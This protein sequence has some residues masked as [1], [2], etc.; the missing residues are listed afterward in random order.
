MAPKIW[1]GENLT[2]FEATKLWSV[3]FAWKETIGYTFG[4]SLVTSQQS[5]SRKAEK[6]WQLPC[7]G[8]KAVGTPTNITV[9]SLEGTTWNRQFWA[10][11]FASYS[12]S[13]QRFLS[14]W[15][16]CHGQAR[17]LNSIYVK[18][19]K[20]RPVLL[21]LFT[22]MASFGE[23]RA[24]VVLPP[25]SNHC[26]KTFLATLVRE[27]LE[28]FFCLFSTPH[29]GLRRI[30]DAMTTMPGSTGDHK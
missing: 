21:S 23:H 1:D 16:C 27:A 12:G 20:T 7:P 15:K 25:F 3:P 18:K 8:W 5:K 26:P 28:A 4:S 24:L 22:R 29:R 30:R 2:Y 17:A 19:K 6:E 10:R 14:S 11:S 13:A 9:L